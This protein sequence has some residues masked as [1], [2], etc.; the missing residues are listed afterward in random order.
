M[1]IPYLKNEHE[2]YMIYNIKIIIRICGS[3]RVRVRVRVR[4]AEYLRARACM[5]MRELVW[6][7]LVTDSSM[8][9]GHLFQASVR[10]NL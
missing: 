3:V 9:L 1:L 7:G 6:E 10:E 2:S 5:I 4:L 8:Q